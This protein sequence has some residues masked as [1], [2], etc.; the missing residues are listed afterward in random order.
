[1]V[2]VVCS[3]C[4]LEEDFEVA[5]YAYEVTL[6]NH[7]NNGCSS[8]VVRGL[9]IQIA[10]KV[11]CILPGTLESFAP[12]AGISFNS[13]AVLPYL[14]AQAKDA[15]LDAAHSYGGDLRLASG[16]RTVAQQFLLWS[17]WKQGRCGI[18]IAATPGRSNHE[19][20]RALDVS[21]W[22]E[23]VNKL[24]NYGWQQ[25]VPGDEVHFDHL[26]SADN[27]GLDVLAFQRLWNDN[28]PGDL[29]DE[30]GIF[31][32]QT[33]SR[34]LKSPADGFPDL[35]CEEDT[36][37]NNDGDG[38]GDGDTEPPAPNPGPAPEPEDDDRPGVVGGC[39]STGGG[40][41]SP[42]VAVLF[43]LG[44]SVLRLSPTG[45]SARNRR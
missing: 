4:E 21:N 39:S 40:P 3:A 35:H 41:S 31:G 1:M 32:P 28:H 23:W 30:D 19:S 10:E 42:W 34:L 16:Y 9:S 26:A 43:L 29:I 22:G 36:E 7:V 8:G 13:P 38:D 20:G 14:D 12:E 33:E 45:R 18:P 6:D 37:P 44:A 17:W 25:T 11:G 24:G 15:L 27:R 5:S 2:L